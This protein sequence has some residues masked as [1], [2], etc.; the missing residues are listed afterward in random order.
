MPGTILVFTNTFIVLKAQVAAADRA[1]GGTLFLCAHAATP[2]FQ[3][4]YAPAS[5]FHASA[6]KCRTAKAFCAGAF[7]KTRIE[8]FFCC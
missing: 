7:E 4:F 2:L 6:S 8:P 1:N 5:F 3:K